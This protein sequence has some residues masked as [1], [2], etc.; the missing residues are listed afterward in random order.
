MAGMNGNAMID[1]MIIGNIRCKYCDGVG[2]VS[3]VHEWVDIARR[4]HYLEE[5]TWHDALVDCHTIRRL[6]H[7]DCPACGGAGGREVWC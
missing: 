6:G 2:R 1:S 7:A 5:W 3:D 4:S